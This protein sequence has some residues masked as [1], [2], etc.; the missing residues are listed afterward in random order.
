MDDLF[1]YLQGIGL[2]MTNIERFVFSS[3]DNMLIDMV[4]TVT[5]ISSQGNSVRESDFIYTTT[6]ELGG[7][8]EFCSYI[9]CRKARIDELAKFAV[10]F[11]D[12]VIIDNPLDPYFFYTSFSE[13][14]RWELIDDLRLLYSIH[15]LLD[16]GLFGFLPNKMHFCKNCF[17]KL[18]EKDPT[19]YE[20]LNIIKNKISK[21]L[22]D[23]SKCTIRFEDGT[24]Y[25]YLEG[26]DELI[27]HGS[28]I[29]SME[30]WKL[31]EVS[32]VIPI[33]DNLELSKRQI[34]DLGFL[35]NI[36]ET[37]FSDLIDKNW[38]RIEYN[39][40]YVTNR[41]YDLELLKVVNSKDNVLK[42]D[43]IMKGLSHTVPYLHNIDINALIEFRKNEHTSFQVYR[44]SIY[45]VIKQVYSKNADVYKEAF[46]DEIKPSLDR[47]EL[48]YKKNQKRLTKKMGS[49]LV[50]G[51]AVVGVGVLGG[52][53]PMSLPSIVSSLGGIEAILALGINVFESMQTP[54]EIETDDLYFLWK[55][56]DL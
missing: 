30:P 53:I 26:P 18:V 8:R 35:D 4:E 48:K 29:I 38:R 47:L 28:I 1:Y 45:K 20:N 10:M 6:S 19:Y 9:D 21:M 51:G 44:N 55:I 50:F 40:K 3:S 27:S 33:K 37:Y 14:D 23:N 41:N 43:A 24:Y 49:T 13:N 31:S 34:K 36:V 56:K 32:K 54:Y 22:E 2:D 17:E 42:N 15:P 16:E 7:S 11:A 46:Q 5:S 25:F 12:S 39:T 52:I